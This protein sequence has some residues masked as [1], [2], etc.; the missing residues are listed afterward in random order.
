MYAYDSFGRPVDLR[1][2]QLTFK[3]ST[4]E[5]AEKL[6]RYHQ[7]LVNP[8][9]TPEL[10]LEDYKRVIQETIA[11]HMAKN[12]TQGVKEQDEKTVVNVERE[13]QLPMTADQLH[14]CCVRVDISCLQVP[15]A[16]KPK[17]R[18]VV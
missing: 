1:P 16:K 13:P 15:E 4:I 18:R 17:R 10:T 9:P 5:Q 8:P 11:E 14:N 7:D 3:V 6:T 12:A 2:I